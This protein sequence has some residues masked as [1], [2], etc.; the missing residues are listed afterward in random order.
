MTRPNSPATQLLLNSAPWGDGSEC[1][2]WI[3]QT[4][5]H[6][7]GRLKLHQRQV[8][9]HRLAYHLLI[10]RSMPLYGREPILRHLCDNQGC[11]NPDHLIPG[12]QI[13]NVQDYWERAKGKPRLEASDVWKMRDL[14]LKD[15]V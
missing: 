7:Y 14:R 1:V 12:T 8:S 3:G 10:D 2:R 11:I 4:D 15:G 13:E 6:G 9:A 5:K